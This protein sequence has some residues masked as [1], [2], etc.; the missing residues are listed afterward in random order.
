MLLLY[1]VDETRCDINVNFCPAVMTAENEYGSAATVVMSGLVNLVV[2][3]CFAINRTLPGALKSPVDPD[4]RA[5]PLAGA[6]HSKTASFIVPLEL[7]LNPPFHMARYNSSPT[8]FALA[9]S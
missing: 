2:E 6:V 5:V 7:C 1:I 4:T 8:H 3:S 9:E